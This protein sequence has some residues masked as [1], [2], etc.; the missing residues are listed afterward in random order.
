M[1]WK[2]WKQKGKSPCLKLKKVEK[3]IQDFDA[4][5]RLKDRK[6]D[7]FILTVD[8]LETGNRT[9]LRM[10]DVDHLEWTM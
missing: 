1:L 7:G 5:A 3:Q 2:E 10:D 6:Q 4:Q 8:N 9:Q